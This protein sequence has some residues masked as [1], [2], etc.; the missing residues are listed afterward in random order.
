MFQPGY[1]KTEETN[2]N[3]VA[4]SGTKSDYV[5]SSIYLYCVS[6][7]I[8]YLKCY[9]PQHFIKSAFLLFLIYDSIRMALLSAPSSLFSR[10]R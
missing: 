6:R 8:C 2:K 10:I 3:T 1:V 5:S 7:K 4:L 9:I